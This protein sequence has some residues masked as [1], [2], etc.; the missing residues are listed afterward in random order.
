[1]S[2]RYTYS[3]PLLS[4]WQSAVAEV[5]RKRASQRKAGMLAALKPLTTPD[6]MLAPARLLGEQIREKGP[7]APEQLFAPSLK[8]A[9]TAVAGTAED[10]AKLAAKF[11]WAEMKGDHAASDLL[12][13]ELK[14][15]VCDDLGWSEV[16]TTYLAFKASLQSLPYRD[17][18]NPVFDL[19]QSTKLAIL[20]DWG[21]GDAPAVGVLQQ[22]AAL[23]PDIVLH[24]GDVYFAGTQNEQRSNFL[25]ICH[26]VLSN[27]VRVFSLCGNH[28][29]Y[30]GGNG[31]YWLVDQLGQQA[32]YFCLQNASWQFLAMDTGHNDNNPITVNSN[33]TSLNDHEAAWLLSK[34]PQSGTPRTVL[35]SHHQLFSPFSS[36]G[37][38]NGTPFAYNPN[39]LTNFQ[40][41][42]QKIVLW[43]WGH[44]HTL[45]IY[46]PYMGLQRGRCVGASA[47]PVLTDQ[48]SYKPGTGLTT[49]QNT[50]LATWAA[51]GILG[52]NGTDYDH[53]FA[54][55]TLNGTAAQVDYYR[56][57]V[58]GAK[59]KLAVG[60]QIPGLP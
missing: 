4:L 5:H 58:L 14:A 6:D 57:P 46:D 28:D 47:V 42:M 29:M 32:S 39:L 54:F 26:Q 59:L 19:G 40:S 50:G 56:V 45:A 25:D 30:S 33:M 48:Q 49:F 55:M 16:L 51:Q 41:V 38:V 3:D 44:E 35:L 20:G 27:N 11:L 18:L 7:T 52:D 43:F 21:T 15:S 2:N 8:G 60:D 22:V 23:Q 10:C 17:G 31:Y 24:L 12:A 53:C 36:V 9:L 34:I 37:K 13:G 1:M